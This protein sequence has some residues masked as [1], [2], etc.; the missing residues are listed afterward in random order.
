M[1]KYNINKQASISSFLSCIQIDHFLSQSHDP[2]LITTPA[3]L[4]NAAQVLNELKI[5]LD[6]VEFMPFWVFVA[7]MGCWG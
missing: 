4:A 1:I 7:P 3:C 2:H 5:K 6:K